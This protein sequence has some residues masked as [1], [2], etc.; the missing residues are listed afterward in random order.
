SMLEESRDS[1]YGFAIYRRP[2]SARGSEPAR[3][4]QEPFEYLDDNS[5]YAY[6]GYFHPWNWVLAVS[7]SAADVIDQIQEYRLQMEQ[8]VR[9]T[10]LPLQLAHSGFVFIVTD[11]QRFVVAP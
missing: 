11:D 2:S 5:R 4:D 8:A 7:D 6:F 3:P 1:G 9:A 10:L